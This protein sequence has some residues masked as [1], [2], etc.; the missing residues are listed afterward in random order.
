MFVNRFGSFFQHTL[1]FNSRSFFILQV[2]LQKGK[3]NSYEIVPDIHDS[4]D[5][6]VYS[7]L[8]DEDRSPQSVLGPLPVPPRALSPPMRKSRKKS[9]EC[10]SKEP[11]CDMEGGIKF[12]PCYDNKPDLSSSELCDVMLDAMWH[13]GQATAAHA[14]QGRCDQCAHFANKFNYEMGAFFNSKQ[15]SSGNHHHVRSEVS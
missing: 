12:N 10:E 13:A 14:G 2:S 1:I 5:D 7:S 11:V 9:C 4:E 6:E 3:D 8:N 15:E